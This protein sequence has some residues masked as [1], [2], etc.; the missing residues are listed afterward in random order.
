MV[1]MI[2]KIHLYAAI[3]GL[4]RAQIFGPEDMVLQSLQQ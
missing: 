3:G 2:I 1:C 4:K